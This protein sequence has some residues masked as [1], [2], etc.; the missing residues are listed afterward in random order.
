MVKLLAVQK[1]TDVCP[2]Q[3]QD[4]AG[5]GAREGPGGPPGT[6]AAGRAHTTAAPEGSAA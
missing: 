5:S 6:A 4:E 1:A 2:G 3:A